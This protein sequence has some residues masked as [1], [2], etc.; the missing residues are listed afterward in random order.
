M[1][2]TTSYEQERVNKTKEKS[3]ME[4]AIIK[5]LDLEREID[6]NIDELVDLKRKIMEI[7]N[8]IES[9]EYRL[10]LEMRYLNF[11]T[12]EDISE[13]L[14]YSYRQVHRIHGEALKMVKV[15]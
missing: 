5:L 8:S 15:S 3:P 6:E 4:N 14:N 7:I 10:V 11:K 9:D 1:K 12:W 2:V 13:S